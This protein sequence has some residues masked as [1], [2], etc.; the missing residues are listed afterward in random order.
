MSQH[1]VLPVARP[2]IATTRVPGS[3]SITNRALLLAALAKG[4]STLT[5][6]LFSDDSEVMLEALK[7]LGV[8]LTIDRARQQVEIEGAA[9][10]FPNIEANVYCRDAGTATR[11]LMAACAAMPH[12]R[13]HF[14]ASERMMQRPSGPLISAL[15]YQGTQFHFERQLQQM[16]FVMQAHG[17]AGGD[18]AVDI[19]DSSQF[20]SGLMMAAPYA[21]Q[22]LALHAGDLSKR[23]YVRMTRS[24]MLAFGI[25]VDDTSGV[26][27][28]LGCYQGCSYAIEPDASTASYFFAIAALTRGEITVEGMSRQSLQG[29]TQ[30]LTVLEKMGCLVADVPSGV[31][32]KGPAQLKGVT[33][34]M[35]GFSDT[36]MT[37]A[38]L[39]PFADTPTTLSG[40]AHTRLQESDRIAAIEEGLNRLG[41][42]TESTESTLT[43][44]PGTPKGAV[45]SGHHDHRIA[46]SLA[47]MGLKTPGVVIDG[48]EC[49]AK[50]CPDYFERLRNVVV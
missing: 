30:F 24:M 11:F 44:Y 21:K 5:G 42:R 4:R 43:I 20:L 47:L 41:I 10:R 39:A 15:Q 50:T 26:S 40:L 32:V 2:I 45:V 12:G 25:A 16:P 3:K 8:S 7:Q 18:V 13:Y 38:V 17:L 22:R 28:Q 31:V 14:S 27:P 19:K 23:P 46:M 37:V 49:V 36:F 29:D 35:T 1:T 9:G 48:A 34:D 6:M 33:V